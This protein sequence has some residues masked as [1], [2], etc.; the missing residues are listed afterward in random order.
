MRAADEVPPT[1]LF[2]RFAEEFRIDGTGVHAFV[3]V[4]RRD[5]ILWKSFDE[6][7]VG[8]YERQFF[9]RLGQMGVLTAHP[10]LL[11]VWRAPSDE[12]EASR[13]RRLLEILES[14]LVRRM[15]L[16]LNT[17]GYGKTFAE[18]VGVANQDLGH[19]DEVIVEWMRA[20][21]SDA[22]RWPDDGEAVETC[23]RVP[24]YGRQLSVTRTAL[25]LTAVDQ[26][27]RTE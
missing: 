23:M 11:L 18:L 15:L 3:E 10:L 22:A 27:M 1:E 9:A 12:L 24:M 13:R 17:R 26:G 20:Q 5:A 4:F 25:V 21:H 6:Q 2:R 16:K 8:S 19:A 14:W 7:P